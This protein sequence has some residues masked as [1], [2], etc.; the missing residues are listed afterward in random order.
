MNAS[1]RYSGLSI[2]NHWITALLVVVM[3][4]LGLAAGNAPEDAE[5]YILSIHIALGFFVLLFVLWRIG[6]RLYEGFPAPDTSR[7]LEAIAASWMH[8]LLLFV[9]LLQVLS[10]PLYLFT[11]GEGMD[12]FGWFTFYI[13]VPAGHDVH[14]AMEEIHEICGEY[15]LPLLAGVHLLGAAKHWLLDRKATSPGDL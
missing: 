9:L 8:K 15:L 13:P 7:A 10:G 2:L 5:D 1:P 6:L 12:V 14:E 11:E 4:V 3:W